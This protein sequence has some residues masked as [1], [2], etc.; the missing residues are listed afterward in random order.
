[1]ELEERALDGA[2]GEPGLLRQHAQTRLDR[3][4]VLTGG[5]TVKKQIDEKR[6]RLLIVPD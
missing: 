6:R 4:P 1:M 2:L 5:A 3:L